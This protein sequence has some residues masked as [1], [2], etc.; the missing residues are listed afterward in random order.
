MDKLRYR[1][2][3]GVLFSS[4]KKLIAGPEGNKKEV[5]MHVANRKQPVSEL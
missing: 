5:L 3:I 1:Q 4:K 2:T